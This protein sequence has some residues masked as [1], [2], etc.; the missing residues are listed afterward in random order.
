MSEG[1]PEND[2][3]SVSFTV[4]L[5]VHD[6]AFPEGS[7]AV[8]VTRVVPSAKV[9]PEAGE[10]EINAEQL[11]EAEAAKFTTALHIPVLLPT[12]ISDGQE[13]KGN[14]ESATVTSNEQVA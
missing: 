1:Q 8:A 11:S 13:I 3:N 7:V 5:N 12:T 2:G 4:T 10:Y 14:S 6:A 9:E